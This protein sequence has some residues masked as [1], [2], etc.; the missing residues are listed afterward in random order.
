[1][2]NVITLSINKT[3]IIS[4]TNSTPYSG[5][6][7]MLG[8]NDQ[9]DSIGDVGAVYYDNFRVV[10]LAAAQPAAPFITSIRRS[11][12]DVVID[13]TAG[14]SD[15]PASFQVEGTPSLSPSSIWSNSGA[16]ITGSSGTFQA[17]IPFNATENRFFRIRR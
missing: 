10:S 15:L 6:K 17:V 4:K 2:G 13:F 9:F 7:V 14:P 3:V 11:G 16:V 12:N 8:V 1:M 5:G